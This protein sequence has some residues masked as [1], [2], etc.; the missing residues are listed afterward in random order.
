MVERPDETR[1]EQV[2]RQKAI[3]TLL[4]FPSKLPG[5]VPI[6]KQRIEEKV[7]F[8]CCRSNPN[9]DPAS[10]A[11][12]SGHHGNL[13]TALVDITL[14]NADGV[15]PHTAALFGEPQMAKCEVKI[16]RQR[17]GNAVNHGRRLANILGVTPDVG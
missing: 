8:I 10:I 13:V 15:H 3:S 16:R 9:K 17:H 6:L 14:V 4:S 12:D 5:E 2:I 1:Y 11:V 7:A